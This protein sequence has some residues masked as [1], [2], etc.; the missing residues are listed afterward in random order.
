MNNVS[1]I[2]DC[3][4]CGVCAIACSKNIIKI[5]LNRNGFYE[6]KIINTEKCVNCKLC[7]NVCAYVHDDIS[8]KNAV[9]KSFAGW[10]RNDDVRFE[11][12]SG[13][14]G[15]EIGR[16]LIKDGYEVCGVRY[17]CELDRAEHYV[18]TTLDE[19]KASVGS[20]YIQS[21]TVDGFKSIDRKKKYLVTGTPCQIDSFRRYIQ[22]FK[23]E[24]NFILL[25][26]F[27]HGVPSMLLWKKYIARVERCTGKSIYVSW[28]NKLTGWHD[29]WVMTVKGRKCSHES[30]SGYSSHFSKGDVF[31]SLFLNNSCLGKAC[32][33]KCKYKYNNSSA[34][35]RIGDMWGRTYKD[36]QTGVSAIAVFTQKGLD[37]LEQCDLGLEEFAFETVAEGQMVEPPKRPLCY[38]WCKLALKMPIELGIV[39]FISKV[40]N[41]C[42]RKILGK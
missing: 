5:N 16:T 9:H 33:E 12:S 14:V 41:F 20:K 4:G 22:K 29:S 30:D 42:G 15:Y 27:C 25:D 13:G 2:T 40:I 10:S 1:S 18:A 19:L 37:C 6:P 17:N 34:D 8:Q 23:I 3:Y 38:K 24:D 11:C 21:Y 35:I 7:V 28:R 31:Y 32:Y 36:N 26:F 39:L